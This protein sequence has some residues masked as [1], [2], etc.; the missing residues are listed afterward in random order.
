MPLALVEEIRTATTSLGLELE[1]VGHQLGRAVENPEVRL[2]IYDVVFG[3]GRL[4]IE[5]LACGCSVIVLGETGCGEM[6][7]KEKV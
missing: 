5:A 4:A 3:S 7:R 2:P 6:V 1:V